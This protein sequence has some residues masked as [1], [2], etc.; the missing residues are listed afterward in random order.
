MHCRI[1]VARRGGRYVAFLRVAPNTP[2]RSGVL[3][4]GGP[5][6]TLSQH[7]RDG[8]YR[9]GSSFSEVLKLG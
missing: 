2:E 7:A 1:H 6:A 4:E 9:S 3:G 5:R 8:D